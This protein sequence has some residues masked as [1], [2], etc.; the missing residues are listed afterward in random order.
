MILNW[1]LHDAKGDFDSK[2]KPSNLWQRLGIYFWWQCKKVRQMMTKE[3]RGEGVKT[4]KRKE[5]RVK[6]EESES[7]EGRK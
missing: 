6:K 1:G 7:E 5:V 4:R 3:K 2:W